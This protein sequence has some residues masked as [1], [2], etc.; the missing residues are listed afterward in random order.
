LGKGGKG[1][2]VLGRK[3]E[4]GEEARSQSPEALICSN[5][6]WEIKLTRAKETDQKK[7]PRYGVEKYVSLRASIQESSSHDK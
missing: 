5:P 4:R 1:K 7:R 6:S 2:K 3:E